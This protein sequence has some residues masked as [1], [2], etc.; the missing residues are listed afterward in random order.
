MAT[1]AGCADG[2]QVHSVSN[3][4]GAAPGCLSTSVLDPS[5]LVARV[6]SD[7]FLPTSSATTQL[8]GQCAGA[9]AVKHAFPTIAPPLSSNS[10]RD[11]HGGKRLFVHTGSGL[12]N[13]SMSDSTTGSPSHC[14]QFALVRAVS[15][16]PYEGRRVRVS[17][18]ASE[19]LSQSAPSPCD[20]TVANGEK[21]CLL[22][23]TSCISDTAVLTCQKNSVLEPSPIAATGKTQTFSSRSAPASAAV[24]ALVLP[25]PVR[26]S[27]SQNIG[28][29]AEES[30]PP[31]FVALS[32]PSSTMALR[33]GGRVKP[34]RLVALD[35]Q[36]KL[37]R[38]VYNRM[39]QAG[40][41][42]RGALGYGQHHLAFV[43]QDGAPV[44]Q[45]TV[46]LDSTPD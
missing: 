17:R 22:R 13:T 43:G 19:S 38:D 15:G 45:R 11:P 9:R 26:G 14:G 18:R 39:M 16:I 27:A 41:Q 7:T 31:S 36:T 21:P 23:A 37:P 29:P 20:T 5:T 1:P 8:A 6:I 24:P 34:A 46:T 4:V 2:D 12:P 28:C 33:P 42:A 35:D 32:S 25:V 3:T 44:L 10:A 40:D 30:L